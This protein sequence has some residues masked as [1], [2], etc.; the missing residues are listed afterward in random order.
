MLALYYFGYRTYQPS[1]EK[2]PTA[3]AVAACKQVQNKR[4]L[5]RILDLTAKVCFFLQKGEGRRLKTFFKNI[6]LSFK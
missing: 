6:I 4:D 1:K 3:T 5:Q 2:L